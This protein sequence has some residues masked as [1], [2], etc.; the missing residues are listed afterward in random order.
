MAIRS[1][2]AILALAG[3]VDEPTASVVQQDVSA[4]VK[5]QRSE[6]IRDSAAEMGLHNAALLGGIAISETSFAHCW[7]EA[8]FAC[9]GPASASCDGGPVIAGSADGPCSAQQ[10]GLGMFQF[11]SGTYAQ[12]LATYGEPVLTVE[13]NTAQ[14][15]AFVVERAIQDI[16][17]VT[18]WVSAVEWMNSIPMK[19]AD[20]KARAWGTFVACRYNGCC[21]SSSLCVDRANKYRD[22]AVALY[23]E[24][25]AEFWN[26]AARCAAIPEDGI[27]DQRSD[28][29]L[30]G[31]EPRYWRHEAEGYAGNREWTGST[32]AA[33]P[34]NFARWH[35][36]GAGSFRLSVHVSGGE[37]TTA[38]YRVVHAG[39]TDPVTIDQAAANG[40]VELGVFDFTGDGTEYV[41]LGDNTGKVDDRVVFD[42]LAITDPDGGPPSSG[43]DVGGGCAAG[44][45]VGLLLG[46]AAIFVR[47][48]R[49]RA[50]SSRDAQDPAS[51]AR[52]AVRSGEV[53]GRAP[54]RRSR[55]GSGQRR[56]R[57]DGGHE[58]ALQG[59]KSLAV[60]VAVAACGGEGGSLR[61]VTIEEL[62]AEAAAVVCNKLVECCTPMEFM[63][64][65]FGGTTIEDCEALYSSFGAIITT[66]LNDSVAN[67]RVVYHGDRVASC[68]DLLADASCVEF[69]TEDPDVLGRCGV[70]FEPR[71]ENGGVCGEDFDCTSGLCDGE[72]IDFETLV[73]TYGVCADAPGL[74]QPCID[75][76]CA[77]GLYCGGSACE[78]PQADGASCSGD[79][80]CESRSCN[81]ANPGV[82]TCGA[83]M[84]CD[85]Q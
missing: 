16:D 73:I 34:S 21:S 39:K 24:M 44:G 43:S 70:S 22:N 38:K 78:E 32:D 67:G 60:L 20:P 42:A 58:S 27:I 53:R 36:H 7:S 13:G 47:G 37:T 76:E 59:M 68:Y 6:L 46:F 45:D 48:R 80:E 17:G 33:A 65:T 15:V 5:R 40:F 57:R 83:I 19:S 4:E 63:D 75:F 9:M 62:P 11:D 25:S 26:T 12:T 71:V 51:E 35:V 49:R 31:G 82:G 23:D 56:E 81:G 2:L 10:G 41:E 61:S 54:G 52:H 74:G 3:C 84:T 18:D 55:A 79:D 77:S 28:C 8:T 72:S 66:T 64:E 29:Y 14:A 50:I 69:R 1:F 85:G 30:A